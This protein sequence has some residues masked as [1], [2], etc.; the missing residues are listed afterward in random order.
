MVESKVFG[1]VEDERGA[2]LLVCGQANNIEFVRKLG[3]QSYYSRTCHNPYPS[4][5]YG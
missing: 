5:D 3:Q 4:V 2:E 1:E